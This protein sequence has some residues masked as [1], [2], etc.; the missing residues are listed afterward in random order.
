[1][2]GM[3]GR[4]GRRRAVIVCAVAAGILGVSGSALASPSKG[5]SAHRICVRHIPSAHDDL[6]SGP[7]RI[8]DDSWAARTCIR[9]VGVGFRV[10]TNARPDDGEVVAYPNIAYGSAYGYTTPGSNLP[11]RIRRM[12]RP[13]M[14]ATADGN[15][16][17]VWIA[18]FDSWFFP[19]SNVAGH[20]TAE[21]VII[22]RY[23]RGSMTG[24][25][26]VTIGG[27]QW[28]V[29]EWTT[30]LHAPGRPC[31]L[32]WPLLRF[33]IARPVRHITI[34]FGSFVNLAV[35]R[36][37]LPRR[38]WW[39]SVSFGFENWSGGRGEYASLRVQPGRP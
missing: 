7:Y 17:G 2:V 19:T 22:L 1:M 14:T 18:D 33:A 23:P 12:G 28:W 32:S 35:R 29:R 10:E 3:P 34:P 36:G 13:R 31:T 16:G 8:Y 30:C 6:I 4:Y 27:R 9:P 26:E 38:D 37:L 24:G 25:R 15:A 11:V 39:G 21:M 5:S 20:G